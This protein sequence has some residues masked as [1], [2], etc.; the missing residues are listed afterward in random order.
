MKKATP[1][2]KTA[3]IPAPKAQDMVKFRYV[4]KHSEGMII[5]SDEYEVTRERYDAGLKSFL[6]MSGQSLCVTVHNQN[7]ILKPMFLSNCVIT[8][9]IIE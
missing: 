9:E 1:F 4:F 2:K 3:P 5:V 8:L 7:T 6:Q